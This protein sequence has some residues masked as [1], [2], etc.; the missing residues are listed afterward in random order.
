[1]VEEKRLERRV[2]MREFMDGDAD[3]EIVADENE[4]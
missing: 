2:G 3:D 4:H 1:M